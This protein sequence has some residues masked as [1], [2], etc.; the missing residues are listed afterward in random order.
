MAFEKFL[1]L[2]DPPSTSK[3]G[4]NNVSN[5]ATE[6]TPTLVELAEK[7]LEQARELEKVIPAPPTFQEDTP[8]NLP[9]EYEK[10]RLSLIDKA[11]CSRRS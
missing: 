10:I 8:A 6:K 5:M 2:L 7:L 3:R 4:S 1:I 11:K 9:Q